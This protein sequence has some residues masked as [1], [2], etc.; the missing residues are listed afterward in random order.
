MVKIKE[1]LDHLKPG[2]TVLVEHP[3]KVE[4]ILFFYEIAAWAE[5]KGYPMVVDDIL[6]TLYLYKMHLELAGKDTSFLNDVKIIKLGGKVNVGQIVG[7]VRIKDEPAIFER[8]Y[9]RIFESQLD[10]GKITVNPVLGLEKLF[11]TEEFKRDLLAR[12]YIPLSLVGDRRRISFY[13]VNTNLIERTV[14]EALP[15]LEEVASTV[16]EVDIMKRKEDV[17][18]KIAYR[19]LITKSV[20]NEL[21]GL[22]FTLP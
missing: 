5:S 7:R 20:N 10:E 12:M 16:L 3:S 19:F 18:G 1:V 17:I 9:K 8:E 14:P 6:D 15:L 11:L 4:P 21:S 2:E 13:F 22:E